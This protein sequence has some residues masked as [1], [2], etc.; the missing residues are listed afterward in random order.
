LILAGRTED[1]LA[2]VRSG[3]DRD[4]TQSELTVNFG[5]DLFYLEDYP[6]AREVLERVVDQ[7][8]DAEAAGV[9]YYA[10]DQLAKLETRIGNLRRAY[11]LELECLQI[12]EPL[13]NEVPLAASLAWLGLVEAMLGRPESRSHAE[14]A[15]EIAEG[16]HD[17]YN[18]LRARGALGLEALGR[19][20]AGVAV[21][22]LEPAVIVASG[23]GVANP[24]FF[25]LEALARVGRSA[26][27]AP[28]LTRFEQQAQATGSAWASASSAR[29]R[30]ILAPEPE[31]ASA[32]ETALESNDQEPSGFERARTELCYGESLRRA[33]QRRRAREQLHAALA[34]FERAGAERWVERCRSELR[35]SGEHIH[36]RDPTITERLT[37]QELQIALVVAEGLTNRDAASRLF[38]SPKTIEFHL[39]RIYRKLEIHS[40]SELVRQMLTLEGE[41]ELDPTRRWTS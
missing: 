40:R 4:H 36:R 41:R 32:F 16:R 6:R 26:D 15:L 28:H 38:L 23:G 13:E 10:L 5:T 27:A 24:N 30:G 11:A 12:V 39:T 1:A 35:A 37:P 33:G 14:A 29:C 31:A 18:A 19:G 20:Y 2:F 22:W 25:R 7:A 17:A 9:L 3:L 8:R 21:D 34:D